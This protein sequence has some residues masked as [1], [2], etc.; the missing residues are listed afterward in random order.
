MLGKICS[1]PIGRRVLMSAKVPIAAELDFKKVS[2]QEKAELA[3]L[4]PSRMYIRLG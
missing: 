3:S 1:V 4:G 2:A